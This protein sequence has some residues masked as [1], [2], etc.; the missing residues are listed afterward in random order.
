MR[1]IHVFSI[2]VLMVFAAGCSTISVQY[3]YDKEVD[4]A[5]LKTFEWLSTQAQPDI[6]PFTVKRIRSATN[7]QLQAKGYTMTS[8]NPDFLI[9]MHIG[10][11]QKIQVRDWGYS[12]GPPGSYWG[13]HRVPA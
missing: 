8:N 6:N 7:E 9:A 2:L 10:K 5:S 11:E 4:F 13:R 3:D 12:Y 1:S